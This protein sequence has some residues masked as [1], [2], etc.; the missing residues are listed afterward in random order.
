MSHDEQPNHPSAGLPYAYKTAATPTTSHIDTGALAT[1]RFA[2]GGGYPPSYRT[3][4]EQYG[5]GR[6]FGLWL[7]YPPVRDGFADGRSR[8][9]RLTDRFRAV[10]HDGQA[11][12]FDW[13]IEPDGTWEVTETLEVFAWSENGDAL[14]WDVSARTPGGEFPVWLST[15][16]NSLVL[17]G[18]DLY[19]ALEQLGA[20]ESVADEA[21]AGSVT[22]LPAFQI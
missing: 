21:S 11:E 4:V 20:S 14:L 3:F 9:E 6:T 13:I 5:W 10:Y 12:G 8:A 22:P 18:R 17:L 2:D 15:G 7:I 19:A 1:H 16:L